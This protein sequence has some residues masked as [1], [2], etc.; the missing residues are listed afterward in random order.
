MRAAKRWT[1][2]T[3]EGT[4]EVTE[5]QP[6]EATAQQGQEPTPADDTPSGW[7]LEGAD[8]LTWSV[9]PGDTWWDDV[10]PFTDDTD[11]ESKAEPEADPGPVEAPAED[12][13]WLFADE[14]DPESEAEP[15]ADPGPVEAP[16]EDDVWLF[17]DDTDSES[18]T[19]P[20]A[21]AGPVEAPVEDDVWLFADET[22]SES[23]PAAAAAPVFVPVEP[24]T[25]IPLQAAEPTGRG[26]P[27]TALVLIAVAAIVVG[28]VLWLGTARHGGDQ[29]QLTGSRSYQAPDPLARDGSLV[30]TQVLANGDLQVTHWIRSTQPVHEVTIRT[31]HV[32]GLQPASVH[33]SGVVLAIDGILWPAV[34]QP[35]GDL[36]SFR[37]PAAHRV[38]VRYR[39]SGAVQQGGPGE[40]A[41]ARI[42][43]ADVETGSP[44]A[45]TTRMVVGAQVLA[46]ACSSP[47]PDAV[48]VPCG[49]DKG[50]EWRVRLGRSDAGDQVMAQ[51]DLS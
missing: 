32:T 39:L 33:V 47:V 30:R 51:L 29:A 28:E 7:D 9:Q 3:D 42:T 31:P 45:T 15:E 5:P 21:D 38:Y 13:V 16:V 25:V 41:L 10:W 8:G 27:W 36:L 19:E 37:V 17:A 4:K 6:H 34:G 46:L 24:P 49:S 40:R 22:D 48:A 44:P 26:F 43:S 50:G 18:E 12:D 1:K 23:E 14:T 20:E 2:R 35:R 11:S